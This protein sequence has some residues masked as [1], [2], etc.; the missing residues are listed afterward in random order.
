MRHLVLLLVCE[1]LPT[2]PYWAPLLLS[3]CLPLSHSLP[4]SLAGLANP[5]CSRLFGCPGLVGRPKIA[6]QT[7]SP[8]LHQQPKPLFIGWQR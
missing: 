5:V 2:T 8:Q 6:E 3:L 1:C 7:I 4:G